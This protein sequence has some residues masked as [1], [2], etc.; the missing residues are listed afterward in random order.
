MTFKGNKI[1]YYDKINTL[2]FRITGNSA[3]N[4]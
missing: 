2:F 3:M 1:I 4:L